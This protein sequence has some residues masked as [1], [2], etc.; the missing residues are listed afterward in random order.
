M[1][2]SVFLGSGSQ[3]LLMVVVTLF[4]A[5]LGFLSPANRGALMTCALAMYACS[6]TI[7]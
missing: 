4:F 5:C 7:A 3:L 6:G 2:L 1:L